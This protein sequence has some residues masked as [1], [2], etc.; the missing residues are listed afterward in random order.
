MGYPAEVSSPSLPAAILAFASFEL[1]RTLRD[2]QVVVFLGFPVVLYPTLIWGMTELGQLEKGR[3]DGEEYTVAVEAPLVHDA[4]GEHDRLAL[5]SGAL[6]ELLAGE[7]DVWVEGSQTR[8]ELHHVPSRPRSTRAAAVV[9]DAI[10]DAYRVSLRQRLTDG[11]GDPSVLDPY[12][13]DDQFTSG[14]SELTSWILGLLVGAIGPLAM[15]LA[16][17]YP[18][19]DLFVVERERDT[20]ETLMVS[21]VPRSVMVAGKL[22]ACAALIFAAALANIG[23]LGLSAVHVSALLLEG[24]QLAAWPSPMAMALA[25][26]TL[27]TAS[28]LFAT[29]MMAAVVPAR[30]YKEGEWVTTTLLFGS[31]P[32]LA[33][34]L[35]G[36]MSGEVH[37]GLWAMPFAH[38]ILAVASAPTGELTLARGFL[39]MG[40]DL[41][42][43]A[44]LMAVLWRTPGP[45]GL[46]TGGWR[47]PWLDRLLGSP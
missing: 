29:V 46:L 23:A 18:A 47:P 14:V 19:I 16:G 10:D 28:L 22:L 44:T 36:L 12:D 45:T 33:L 39:A 30:T 26:G 9:E 2:P 3:H 11:G 27:A 43:T 38:T 5:G 37:D 6:P 31:F 7:I 42:A 24:E 17:V 32:L 1:R 20:L 35:L 21:A 40:T 41:L 8:F 15:L 25:A 4:L 34:A 13:I